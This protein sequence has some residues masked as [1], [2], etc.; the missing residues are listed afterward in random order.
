MYSV[1][2]SAHYNPH[3]IC[4]QSQRAS[5]AILASKAAA[6]ASIGTDG[7]SCAR[8]MGPSKTPALADGVPPS[9]G[10]TERSSTMSSVGTASNAPSTTFAF[11]PTSVF[12]DG[13]PVP[14]LIAFDLDYTLWPF[15]V[16]THVCPPLKLAPPAAA[17]GARNGLGGLAGSGKHGTVAVDRNGETFAFYDEVPELLQALPAAG[18]RV[19]AASRTSAPELAR[20]LLRLLQVPAPRESSANG[21]AGGSSSGGGG[22][23]GLFS[24]KKNKRRGTGL[25]AGS[26]AAAGTTI[27]ALDAFDA[28]LEIY[29]GS[30][31]RHMEALQRRTGVAYEDILFFD[32]ES[33]NREVET[34]GVTM[35]LVRDG[36]TWTEVEQGVNEWRRRRGFL[37]SRG[38]GRGA[39]RS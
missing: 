28:G 33:R 27:R 3:Y 30:K 6:S 15:W 13:L 12:L 2:Y 17:P 23:G 4:I 18:V 20:D 19:A 1:T 16:D 24:V 29:P 32:D 5:T 14:H 10:R 9:G 39:E 22:G 37:Q 38:R 8:A 21:S 26:G 36:V 35:R 31:L 25:S 7:L 11:P 34:L